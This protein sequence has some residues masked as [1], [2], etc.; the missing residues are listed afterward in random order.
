MLPSQSMPTVSGSVH[1]PLVAVGC[2]GVSLGLDMVRVGVGGDRW[3]EVES[4]EVVE[5]TRKG[6]Y[7]ESLYVAGGSHS[8]GRDWRHL[9]LLY[10]TEVKGGKMAGQH[11]QSEASQFLI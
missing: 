3:V 2:S 8:E 4:V 5:K 11:P 10:R 9:T 1:S 7:F 6:R